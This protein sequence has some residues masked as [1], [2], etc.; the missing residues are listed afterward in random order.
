MACK[1]EYIPVLVGTPLEPK[2]KNVRQYCDECRL[3]NADEFP[4]PKERHI[5]QMS[6]SID[7]QGTCLNIEPIGLKLKGGKD[8]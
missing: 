1:C 2:I 8:D 4:L 3:K 7:W 6:G 5:G